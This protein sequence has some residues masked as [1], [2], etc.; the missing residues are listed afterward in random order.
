VAGEFGVSSTMGG[1]GE[2][3][4]VSLQSPV[5]SKSLIAGGRWLM[6]AHVTRCGKTWISGTFERARL[7]ASRRGRRPVC[8]PSE[9]RLPTAAGLAPATQTRVSGPT[10][11]SRNCG[12]AN[13]RHQPTTIS[14]QRFAEDW[15][16]ATRLYGP[17]DSASSN[18]AGR[19]DYRWPLGGSVRRGSF[20]AALPAADAPGGD[21][22]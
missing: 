5:F 9:A 6:A 12:R 7:G 20:A 10:R 18:R 11:A 15:R 17:A 2:T 13:F 4:V 22:E 16:L 19:A 21:A 1:W 3:L 14:Y 8:P